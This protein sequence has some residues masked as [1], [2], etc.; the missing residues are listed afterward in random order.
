MLNQPSSNRLKS[1]KPPE[2]IVNV[3]TNIITGFLGVG[4][5]TA[6]L[7]LLKSKPEHE[8][9]AVLV[10]EFG[11]VG[12][13]GALL[14]GQ[15]SQEQG[16][17]IREVPG[18][19]MC[20]AA[21]LPMQIALNMLLARAKPDRL[22]IEPTGLGHP[23]EVVAALQA[24]HFKETI[25]LQTVVTLVDGRN[26]KDA[27]YTEHETFNQQLQIAD[28]IVANK[29]DQYQE[30]ELENLQDYLQASPKTKD[31]P[32]LNTEQGIIDVEQLYLPSRHKKP[33][34][35]PK[36][37]AEPTPGLLPM[38][39]PLFPQQGYL[40]FEHQGEGFYSCGWVFHQRFSFAAEAIT[41]L[42]KS[43]SAQRVKAVLKT[44]S[45]TTGYNLA[46]QSLSEF[47][48][49]GANDSRFELISTKPINT[50]Q[51]EQQLLSM[52]TP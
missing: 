44:E 28:L 32:L 13:D 43:L 16:V 37:L 40:R 47:A 50:D 15:L 22:L 6:I 3:P 51:L 39:V 21:G 46:E 12:I 11:E 34:T 42:I 4:K 2:P 19:C 5:T 45:G 49:K 33:T 48:L 25:Q 29:V 23:E 30:D 41:T 27:R 14:S 52:V 8:R 36:T 38:G 35:I 31:V 7:N 9:W 1:D 24:E 10:N 17:F 18:G 26:I 20:C